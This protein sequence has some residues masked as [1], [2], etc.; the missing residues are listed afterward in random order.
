MVPDFAIKLNTKKLVE[1]NFIIFLTS[2]A[3]VAHRSILLLGY[4]DLQRLC[5]ASTYKDFILLWHTKFY[6]EM[7]TRAILQTVS[8]FRSIDGVQ[9]QKQNL[10]LIGLG[11]KWYGYWFGKYRN[12]MC[13]Y[14]LRT[15][16]LTINSG[17]KYIDLYIY[18]A[19]YIRK[20]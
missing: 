16:N 2:L 18:I 8:V 4:K 5:F 13:F 10:I 17:L 9:E 14:P 1:Q 12:V 6:L 3:N 15:F 20:K 11:I 7:R 19:N